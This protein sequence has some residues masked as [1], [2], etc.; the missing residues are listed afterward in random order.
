MLSGPKGSAEPCGS[1]C[2]VCGCRAE[3][4]ELPGGS[5]KHCLG[6]SAD[7][8]TSIL[9]VTEIDAATLAGQDTEA[10]VAE[11]ALLS[12]RLLHRAQSE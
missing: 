8:A 9:L 3:L 12:E 10:L 2:S 5:E 6:C 11:L 4:Y 1:S 7:V